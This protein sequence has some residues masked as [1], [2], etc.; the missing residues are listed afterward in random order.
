VLKNPD[1][2]FFSLQYGEVKEELAYA[3]EVL[4]I[5]IYS[6]PD[7]DCKNNLDGLV[8]QM[9]ALDLV[10]S[11][12]N[13]NAHLAAAAGVPTWV[14]VPCGPGLFWCWG[15]RDVTPFYPQARLFR[16]TKSDDW[17]PVIHAIAEALEKQP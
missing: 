4:G 8:A 3:K 15:Y 6:D 17:L 5:D 14:T 10:I 1:Y 2:Q 13:T 12:A 9:G 16:A 7:I 11:A